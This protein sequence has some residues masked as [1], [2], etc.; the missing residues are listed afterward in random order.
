M[1]SKALAAAAGL[2]LISA[3]AAAISLHEAAAQALQRD[4]RLTAAHRAADGSAADVETARAGFRPSVN[5][6]VIG[7]RSRLY[8]D[9]PFPV[10]G[11][12]NP[13]SWGLVATQPL[14]SGGLVSAQIA[15]ARS[16]LDAA[17]ETEVATEQQLLFAASSAWLDVK[18]DRAVV[19]LNQRNAD[20]L[21]QALD[22]SRKRFAAG[23][24]TKTDVA[25]A[26]ARLAEAQASLERARATAAVSAAAFERVVGAAPDDLPGD[27][28]QP[29]VPAS[30]ADALAV[31]AATPAV[32][33]AEADARAARAQIAAEQAGHLPKL[34]LEGEANDADDSTFTYDRQTY[35]SV[36]L[37][38][39]LPIYAGGAVSSRVSAA[40]AHAE[41]ADAT[42]DD[43]RRAAQ[44]AIAQAWSL[45]RAADQ[46]IAAY[47]AEV[48]A[49]ELALDSVRRELDV[50]TRT[51]LD[52]LDAQRDLLAA[53]VN[54]AG[55]RH[56][57]SLAALQ[58]LGATGRLSLD[59][60]P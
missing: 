44:E 20:T 23:E 25:Q 6:S 1:T 30:L 10:A 28:P 55:S 31:A 17:R 58:L 16:R 46:V 4:P 42:A 18:R 54:L 39:T 60:I 19:D 11:P 37:K 36:Q 41:A 9:A 13:L 24:A 45:Y 35:W 26:E 3:D 29:A 27:W 40:R 33:A 56:D 14:Y 52:L 22:D 59:A 2:L 51:T 32:R 47:Q 43:T 21:Q 38:A 53:T 50:G 7:G 8:S 57:R 12:R 48:T 49:S 15:G 34:S 5:A